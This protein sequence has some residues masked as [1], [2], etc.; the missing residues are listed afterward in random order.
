MALRSPDLQAVVPDVSSIK[1]VLQN[2]IKS[3]ER[4]QKYDEG[5]VTR[6]LKYVEEWCKLIS[7]D[8]FVDNPPK[9]F[10]GNP[11]PHNRDT[12]QTM[13]FPAPTLVSARY[14]QDVIPSSVHHDLD[15]Y[16]PDAFDPRSLLLGPREDDF[17][18]VSS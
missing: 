10:H 14:Q 8:I 18:N 9:V 6:T 4:F 16:R 13:H 11:A 12:H 1:V 17:W 7:F 3:I 15:T 2:A 5:K